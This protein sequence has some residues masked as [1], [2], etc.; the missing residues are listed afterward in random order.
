[1][2]CILSAGP[3]RATRACLTRLARLGYRQQVSYQPATRFW[4]LQRDETLIYLALAAVLA[5]LGTCWLRRR[6]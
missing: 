1:M 3:G 5:G 4:A 2:N 6:T